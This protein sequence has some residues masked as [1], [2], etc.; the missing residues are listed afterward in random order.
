MKHG[1]RLRFLDIHG[2]RVFL[3]S[4]F[5]I[6]PFDVAVLYFVEDIG[7][8]DLCQGFQTQLLKFKRHLFVLLQKTWLCKC[9]IMVAQDFSA[10]AVVC[11][12]AIQKMTGLAVC[13]QARVSFPLVGSVTFRMCT[14]VVLPSLCWGCS[15]FALSQSVADSVYCL[16]PCVTAWSFSRGLYLPVVSA[17]QL[18]E[19]SSTSPSLPPQLTS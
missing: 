10:P 1:T 4:F 19:R 7:G 16:Q 17:E 13:D 15:Y 12:P 18:S 9:N 14:R 8:R 11:F 3:G 6:H 2:W 5:L